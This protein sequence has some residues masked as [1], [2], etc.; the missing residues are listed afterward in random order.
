MAD[1]TGVDIRQRLSGEL[2]TLAGEA[3][4]GVSAAEMEKLLEVPPKPEMG[5]FALP[6]F[7]LA[8]RLRKNPAQ[9]AQDLA[10][11]VEQGRKA[12]TETSLIRE[13][14]SQGPYLN[15]KLDQSG[16]IRRIIAYLSTT[17]LQE[18]AASGAGR[19]VVIDF[20][21]PNIAKPFG[22][23]HLRSTV[24]GSSLKK[25]FSFLG[26]QV[27]GINHLGDWGTQFG[28]LI[29][30][31]RKWG[32]RSRLDNQPINYLYSLYVRFHQEAEQNPDLDDEARLWFQKMEKGDPEALELW[33]TFSRLSLK[34]FQRIYD[35]LGVSFEAF[36]GESFYSDQL[37]ATLEQLKASG[38]TRESEG[39]L[40]IPMNG[41]KGD[42]EQPPIL[43]AKRDGSTLYITRDIA[44][45]LYRH[46][47]YRFDLALYVVGS[48]QAL[49]F[50]QLF[51]VLE[52]MGLDW[53][54][55]CHHVA[56]GQIRFKEGAMSTRR[57]NIVL[58][59]EVLD[60]AVDLAR[61]IM[62]EKNP[63]L[64][65]KDQVAEA[66]GVGAVIFNDLKNYRIKDIVF[67]WDELMNFNGETG[68]YLQ[69]THARMHSLVQRY[70]QAYGRP[71][72]SESIQFD[73]DETLYALAIQLN[74]F[75]ETVLKAAENFEPSF[76]SRYL[77]ELAS[78]F[79]SFYNTHRVVS[80]DPNAS[81]QRI[82][83]VAAVKKVLGTGLSLLG[84][85]PVEEM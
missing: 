54:R 44:A 74:R 4:G 12:N 47:T 65:N 84:I 39:A 71:A 22:I 29:T 59:E 30:A 38:I 20:S 16:V 52:K 35:R 64:Q 79:N 11:A 82:L 73:E 34:E 1:P 40:V 48:P 25:I 51:T 78:K 46:R 42:P 80:E 53:Y 7:T 8:K 28:K 14:A 61:T 63:G 27:V 24:I 45:A 17:D 31:Y 6:C 55:S 32:D 49:H 70:E 83:V 69:Y 67:D 43:L 56:F 68:V 37:S 9:I 50:Q 41:E 60:K 58:L 77:L 66:V 76:I 85:V 75:P 10:E 72:F 62:E 23:G 13:A 57:G 26:W 18:F 2:H 19:T 3:A 81:L 15:L 21:S 33:Q 5:D 36:T